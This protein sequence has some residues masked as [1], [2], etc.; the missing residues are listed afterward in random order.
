MSKSNTA[1]NR[2]DR[3]GSI[4][5]FYGTNKDLTDQLQQNCLQNADRSFTQAFQCQQMT[6]ILTLLTIRDSALIIHAPVGCTGCALA[7][8]TSYKRGQTLRGI[9]NPINAR[10]V[11]TNLDESDVIHG[12]EKKLNEA[13]CTLIERYSPKVIFIVTSCASAIIG[14]DV[15]NVINQAQLKTKT[16]LVPI[17][18]EGFKSK[19]SATGYDSSYNAI[20]E[21][22]LE[23]PTHKEEKLINVFSPIS[24][25]KLDQLEMERLLNALDLKCNFVPCFSS[26]D[27]IKRITSAQVSTSSCLVHGDNFME[28]LEERYNIPYAK[29]LMPL[30]IENTD[31]WLLDLAKIIGKTEE[32]KALIEKEHKKIEPVL[33][34]LRKQLKGIRAFVSGGP[35]RAVTISSLAQELGFE[36]IGVHSFTF[37]KLLAENTEALSKNGEEF[38]F[39]V[40]NMQPFEHANLINRLKP[41]I[42]LGNGTWISKQGIPTVQILDQLNNSLGYN[43]VIETG[44]KIVAA[45]QN[46]GF[47]LKFAKY[48]KLPYKASWFDENP[49]KYLKESEVD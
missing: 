27:D 7:I 24:C 25:N 37:D 47:N 6:S 49:I 8:N 13:I 46:P 31:K 33:E 3:L 14:D 17:H 41:D 40:A 45:L 26:I 10:W 38:I 43:G 1:I 2:E 29:A 11:S 21:Y 48:K 15:D 23:P 32:A 12:G 39:D 35:A 4:T 20:L 19:I 30:G 5:G 42:F 18:C 9:S 34:Q 36:I 44:K 22:F 28:I 16:F